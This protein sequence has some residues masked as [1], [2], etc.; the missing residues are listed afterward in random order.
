MLCLCFLDKAKAV[1]SIK[2]LI[3]NGFFKMHF[4]A[5]KKADT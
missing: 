3:F 1:P 5:D 4:A 2:A